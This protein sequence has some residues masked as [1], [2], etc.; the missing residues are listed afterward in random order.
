MRVL[1]ADPIASLA[2][3]S[4]IITRELWLAVSKTKCSKLTDSGSSV[5][6]DLTG[7]TSY[8][9]HAFRYLVSPV[10]SRSY[11]SGC[12][13]SV[14]PTQG[15]LT[16]RQRASL[17]LD[18]QK[19]VGCTHRQTEAMLCWSIPLSPRPPKD[20]LKWKNISHQQVIYWSTKTKNEGKGRNAEDKDKRKTL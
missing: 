6:T 8:S 3:L 20:I 5:T 14:N 15:S 10:V 12:S 9:S 1:S 16:A 18:L 11:F 19:L 7:V 17:Y 4:L 13:H 2:A